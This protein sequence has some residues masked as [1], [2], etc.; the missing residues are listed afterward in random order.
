M[1]DEDNDDMSSLTHCQICGAIAVDDDEL[2]IMQCTE[3]K[4]HFAS[5]W[6]Y[7]WVEIK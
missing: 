5:Y 1:D 2:N 3:S 7:E 6:D 4:L